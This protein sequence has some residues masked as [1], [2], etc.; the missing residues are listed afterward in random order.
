MP[1]LT[2]KFMEKV[3]GEYNCEE[4]KSMTIGR[5]PD[6]DI[7]IENLGASAHHAKIDC[8]SDTLLLTDLGSTNGTFVNEEAVTSHKLKMGDVITIAKHSLVFSYAEGET[9]PEEPESLMDKTMIMDAGQ[10]RAMLGKSGKS[11]SA[12]GK[13]K[14]AVLAFLSGNQEEYRISKKLTKIG[15]HESSDIVVSGL[16]VGKTAATVSVRPD[17]YY[18]SY[19][20]GMSKPKVN[21]AAVKQSVKLNEFD[22]IEVGSAKAELIVK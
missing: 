7:V 11:K 6:N 3:L 17:G 10:Q 19:V 20:G 16:F 14:A 22:V 9:G 13:G 12:R 15:K 4:G 1:N 8:M 2:L 21:G 5:Q 18:L